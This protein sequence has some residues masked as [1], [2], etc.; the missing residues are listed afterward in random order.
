MALAFR[1]E[2]RIFESPSWLWHSEQSRGILSH[3]HGLPF[4]AELRNFET[5]SCLAIQSST[6]SQGVKLPWLAVQ[7]SIAYLWSW[8]QNVNQSSVAEPRATEV[9]EHM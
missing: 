5:P 9:A 7:S 8:A 1:A 3:H 6:D 4:R 2:P